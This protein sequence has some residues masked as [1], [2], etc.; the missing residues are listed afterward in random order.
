[1]SADSVDDLHAAE[2]YIGELAREHSIPDA[3]TGY[4]RP[5]CGAEG[6]PDPEACESA[7]DV[8]EVCGCPCHHTTEA[9]A[10]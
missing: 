8:G 7:P 3:L 4:C 2:D 9:V 10:S 5:T 6:D 1:M